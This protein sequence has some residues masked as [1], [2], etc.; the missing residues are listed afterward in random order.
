MSNVDIPWFFHNLEHN[1]NPLEIII[2][3]IKLDIYSWSPWVSTHR[4]LNILYY[5]Q[6]KLCQTISFKTWRYGLQTNIGRFR[7]PTTIRREY[8]ILRTLTYI[9][10]KPHVVYLLYRY[11]VTEVAAWE[12]RIKL[13]I[14]LKN[15]RFIDNYSGRRGGTEKRSVDFIFSNPSPS[16][17][18]P[19]AITS[20]PHGYKAYIAIN[21]PTILLFY[22]L[23]FIVIVQYCFYLSCV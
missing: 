16:H 21:L 23:G 12:Q 18:R 20:H 19:V 15:N 22:I 3:T 5:A 1:W 13:L 11:S 2:I 8:I 6:N 10:I 17:A 9:I 7:R 14:K 4:Q